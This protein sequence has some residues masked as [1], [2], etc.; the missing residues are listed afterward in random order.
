LVSTS[1]PDCGSEVQKFTLVEPA[2]IAPCDGS[3][4][5]V[6]AVDVALKRVVTVPEQSRFG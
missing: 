2:A 6:K 1:A 4:S 5:T 3:I